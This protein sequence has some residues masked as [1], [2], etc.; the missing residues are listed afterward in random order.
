[1]LF[2]LRAVLIATTLL[3][4]ISL[5]GGVTIITESVETKTKEKVIGVFLID[6]DN[7]RIEPQ[8]NGDQT[9][10][11]DLK[12]K[13][14]TVLNHKEKSYMSMTKDQIN[15]MKVKMK[16]QMKAIMAQQKAALA[17]LAPEQRA[18]VEAQMKMM[19]GEEKEVP[20][21]YT[22]TGKTEKWNGKTCV[23]YTGTRNGVKVEEMCTVPPKNLKCS[24]I[25]LERLVQ[26]GNEYSM[27][28][29]GDPSWQEFKT[30]GV[31]VKN[32]TYKDGKILGTHSIVS[33]G[34][35]KIGIEKFKIP[36]GYKK[37]E[38][39]KMPEK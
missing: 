4:T 28:G 21:K 23:S 30:R 36:K 16:E 39:P 2:N 22:K 9:I 32:V 14:V 18:A 6:G 17:Q 1:M 12:K 27:D 11:Y 37:T 34:K 8:E 15:Q 33:I 10:L 3:F 38:I 29:Q 19:S 35:T 20:V 5:F 7:V 25:E 24:M 13:T 31:P 26:I